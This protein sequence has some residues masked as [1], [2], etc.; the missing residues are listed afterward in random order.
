MIFKLAYNYGT[1]LRQD[2][3]IGALELPGGL[4]LFADHRDGPRF[5]VSPIN[6]LQTVVT[7]V[8]NP[9]QAVVIYSETLWATKL[10]GGC[11]VFAHL[12]DELSVA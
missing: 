9:K 4:A 10:K 12:I 5:R 6:D 1:V 7:G 3:T 2:H 11:A 8:C